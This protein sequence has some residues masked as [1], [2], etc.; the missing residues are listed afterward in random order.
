MLKKTY[1]VLLCAAAA[2]G[3]PA[4]ADTMILR[5]SVENQGLRLGPT[6]GKVYVSQG[7]ELTSAMLA[8]VQ[9][10]S[11]T[12]VRVRLGCNLTE[13]RNTLT[14]S[15]GPDGEVLY[16]QSVAT[17]TAGWNEIRLDTPLSV[18][19]Q[20]LFV[21]ISLESEGEMISMD[22]E[23]DNAHANWIKISYNQADDPQASWGHQSGGAHNICVVVEGDNLPVDRAFIR[24]GTIRSYAPSTGYF[25]IGLVVSNNGSNTIES[26]GIAVGIDGAEP[27]EHTVQGIEIEPGTTKYIETAIVD[28]GAGIHDLDLTLVAANGTPVVVGDDSCRVS[29]KDIIAKRNYSVR[30][31]VL[32][33]FSTARCSNCPRAHE[34][35]EDE[36]LFRPDVIHVVHHAG[37]G[38]DAYTVSDSEQYLWFYGSGDSAQPYTPAFMLDRTNMAQYGATNGSTATPGPVFSAGRGTFGQLLEQSLSTPALT[39]LTLASR[40]DGNRLIV[41]VG[42]SIPGGSADLLKTADLRLGVMVTEDSIIGMQQDGPRTVIQD[43]NHSRTLRRVLTDTWGDKVSFNG[44]TLAPREY[45][46]DLPAEWNRANLRVVAFLSG[47]D[48]RNTNNC[49]ILNGAECRPTA[50]SSVSEVMH[51]DQ[52]PCYYNLQGLSVSE[53]QL[54]PGYYIERSGNGARVI[55]RK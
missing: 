35:V 47:Y 44:A 40:I 43:Y 50:A 39:D 2:S 28:L 26:L 20:P 32:E 10:A 23:A 34:M 7:I 21:G 49:K 33:H 3:Q 38:T 48:S 36:L 55:Y 45:A 12:A 31:V 8:P 24:R 30:R 19:G 25:P 22:G 13:Q 16:S 15:T 41:N 1:I 11:I 46:V 52:T 53:S 27:T 17:L 37:F 6:L 14:I 18:T 51:S 9:G 5:H 42:A 4:V 29:K 54:V